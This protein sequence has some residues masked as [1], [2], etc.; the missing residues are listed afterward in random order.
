MKKRLLFIMVLFLIFINGTDAQLSKFVKNVKN[1]VQKDL[2]GDKSGSSKTMPEPACACADAQLVF[3]LGGKLK[4]DYSEIGITTG[5]D[6]RILVQDIA[7]SKYYIIKDGITQG[8]YSFDDPAVASFGVSKSG[9]AGKD[10]MVRYKEYITKTGDKYIITFG[11][12]KYGP[13]AQIMQFGATKSK[14]KFAAVVI[15][16]IAVS[17]NNAKRMEEAYKKAK[18]DEEK[19]N[20]AMQFAQEMQSNV[21]NVDPQSFSPRFISNISGAT[22]DPMGGIGGQFT[23]D[24]KYDDILVYTYNKITDLKGNLILS[25]DPQ[26]FSVDGFFINTD[27]SNYA[28]FSYGT[29]TFK[30]NSKL[31]DV[32][33]PHWLKEGGKVY[34]AYMYYSPKRNAIMQCKL[35]F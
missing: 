19:M 21:S 4:L 17:E 35:P 5:D 20:L 27:N 26:N 33:N 13:Y 10:M 25:I 32:F 8:P 29:L 34:L 24:F 11:G 30:N 3:E 28:S 15:E 18:T 2:L 16:N 6:G 7:G 31:T 9:D 12:K 22:Y 23:S 1:T 14:D